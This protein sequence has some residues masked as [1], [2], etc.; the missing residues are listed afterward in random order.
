MNYKF[1]KKVYS[2]TGNLSYLSFTS[3]L[4]VIRSLV[5]V[6]RGPESNN[7]YTATLIK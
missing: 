1:I 4:T 2:D 6:N 5:S 3:S 7:S